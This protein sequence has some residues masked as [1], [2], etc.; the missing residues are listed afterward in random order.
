LPV[1][2]K[3]FLFALAVGIEPLPIL[4]G[5]DALVDVPLDVGGIDAGAKS[6]LKLVKR[7]LSEHPGSVVVGD[8]T[9]ADR[10]FPGH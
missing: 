9:K 8:V 7:C 4:R 2:P 1:L 10:R 5:V 3:A 6:S